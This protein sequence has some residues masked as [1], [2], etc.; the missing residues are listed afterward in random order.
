MY[1]QKPNPYQSYY[2]SS[3]RRSTRSVPNNNNQPS[4]LKKPH[5][6]RRVAGLV[7]VVAVLIL[8]IHE[9]LGHHTIEAYSKSVIGQVKSEVVDK[10]TTSTTTSVAT[11]ASLASLTTK[12][13]GIIAQNSQIDFSVSTVDLS[14][15]QLQHYGDSAAFTAASVTKLITAAD[16]LSNVQAG[17]QS[18][19]ETINGSSAEYELQ[20][21]IVVSD[22]NAWAALNNQLG[23]AN[24]ESYATSIGLTNYQQNDNVNT[25]PSNDIAILLQKLYEGQLLNTTNTDMLLSWMKQANY[26]EYIVPAVPGS[27]TIYHKIGLYEDFVNDAA[28]ITNGKQTIVLVIFTNGNGTYNWTNRAT[29]M[30]Q[31]TTAVLQTYLVS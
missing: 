30:Q 4:P 5:R 12:I 27:D 22:D 6:F 23:Y 10:H 31:L 7:M 2:Y 13:N 14:N 1:S 15:N 24:L 18:L 3:Q 28:I 19:T 9:V 11:A 26:R 25:I 20:Q 21:M 29:I 17:K 8:G 16:F